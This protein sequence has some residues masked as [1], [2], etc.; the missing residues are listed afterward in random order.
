MTAQATQIIVS[1]IALVG[2]LAPSIFAFLQPDRLRKQALLDLE[3]LEKAKAIGAPTDILAEVEETA[4]RD[5]QR[6]NLEL[7]SWK[8]VLVVTLFLPGLLVAGRLVFFWVWGEPWY[9][10][11]NAFGISAIWVLV[12]L[13]V[14]VVTSPLG[15]KRK[16]R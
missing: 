8:K 2:V 12:V 7:P 11:V 1:L 15:K 6:L 13:Y 9:K 14:L 16:A 10:V 4:L 3:V 5:T